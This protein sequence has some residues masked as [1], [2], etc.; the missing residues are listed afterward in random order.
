MITNPDDIQ[1][2]IDAVHDALAYQKSNGWPDWK[3]TQFA[4]ATGFSA[5]HVSNLASGVRRI[6]PKQIM[7]CRAR[8]WSFFGRAGNLEVSG[9]ISV[10]VHGRPGDSTES[11]G[12]EKEED[13]TRATSARKSNHSKADIDLARF[14]TVLAQMK[15]VAGT[16]MGGLYNISK[17]YRTFKVE[18]TKHKDPE[19]WIQ[20][21]RTYAE[22]ELI[23]LNVYGQELKWSSSDQEIRDCRNVYFKLEEDH[24]VCREMLITYVMWVRADLKM[25]AVNVLAEADKGSYDSHTLGKLEEALTRAAEIISGYHAIV[26]S[27]EQEV[28][29]TKEQLAVSAEKV[30][31]LDRLLTSA[32]KRPHIKT[33][34]YRAGM[35]SKTRVL[36]VLK[37][38]GIKGSVA[39][40]IVALWQR[41]CIWFEMRY[42]ENGGLR[43]PGDSDECQFR[44]KEDPTLRYTHTGKESTVLPYFETVETMFMDRA[45]G[46]LLYQ[47]RPTRSYSVMVLAHMLVGADWRNGEVPAPSPLSRSSWLPTGTKNSWELNTV[48]AKF[49]HIHHARHIPE[50]DLDKMEAL[51]NRMQRENS[52]TS[53]YD[54]LCSLIREVNNGEWDDI[55]EIELDDLQLKQLRE[56]ILDS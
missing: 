16:T 8:L 32:S 13:T 55:C 10:L 19:K 6:K 40:T 29:E 7:D 41:Q 43:Y 48:Q 34:R 33:C 54:R 12:A 37:K 35:M 42:G 38:L 44:E 53:N 17:L 5:S 20:L 2:A 28:A 49:L 36:K 56:D 9:L 14:K 30:D 31:K 22:M 52:Y 25:A 50:E 26:D 24:C 4:D 3:R 11:Q 18:F 45:T 27:K 46:K 21:D 23:A 51:Y 15:E 39:N 47:Q 1:K